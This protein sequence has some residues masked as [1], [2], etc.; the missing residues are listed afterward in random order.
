MNVLETYVV[1]PAD[2][3]KGDGIDVVVEDD[4]DGDEKQKTG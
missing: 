1:L 3:L 4:R 2:F